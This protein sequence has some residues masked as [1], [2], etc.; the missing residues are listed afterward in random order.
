[1]DVIS[2]QTA[3]EKWG[4]SERRIQK[5]CEEGRIGGVQRMGRMWLIPENADKPND[6][7]KQRKSAK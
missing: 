4:I 2:V 1:M 7:R 3:A 5:L 6:M